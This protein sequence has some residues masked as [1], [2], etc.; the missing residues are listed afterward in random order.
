MKE[1]M[2]EILSDAVSTR[3]RRTDEQSGCKKEEASSSRDREREE[4][5]RR[6]REERKQLEAEEKNR[7][8]TSSGVQQVFTFIHTYVVGLK[9]C[10]CSGL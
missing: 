6:R 10:Q 3:V 1:L 4:K 2:D 8:K 9:G 7:D 5:R